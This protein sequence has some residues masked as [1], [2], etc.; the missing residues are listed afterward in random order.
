MTVTD[1]VLLIIALA[2]CLLVVVQAAD[3]RACAAVSAL[4]LGAV[5][6]GAMA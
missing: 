6:I 3:A 2:C 4:C 5:L 1:N